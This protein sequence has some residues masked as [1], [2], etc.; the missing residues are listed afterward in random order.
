MQRCSCR[1]RKALKEKCSLGNIGFIAEANWPPKV[2][3]T[4]QLPFSQGPTARG[5]DADAVL[6]RDGAPEQHAVGGRVPAPL[7]GPLG[8]DAVPAAADLQ[9]GISI[10]LRI[11]NYP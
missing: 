9:N 10:A 8:A 2:K 11:S 5:G 6:L 3:K 7:E 1:N 4:I